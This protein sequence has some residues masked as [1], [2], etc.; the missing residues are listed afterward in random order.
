MSKLTAIIS[1]YNSGEWLDNRINN[2]MQ[3]S[4]VSDMEIVCVNANSPDPRDDDIPQRYPVTYFKLDDR[5]SVYEAWNYAIERT[6]STYIVNA[7]SDD[8]VSPECYSKLAGVLDSGYDFCYPSWFTTKVPNLKWG[9]HLPH[10]DFG[11][12][13]GNYNGDL[14][15]SGVGHFPMWRRSLHDKVGYFDGSFKALG[16]AEFWARCF[17]TAN[18]RFFWLNEMLAVYLW[19]DGLNLWSTSINSD[20]WSRYHELVGKYRLSAKV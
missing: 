15:R 11:G 3:S 18:A 5:I 6:N 13:P 12:K 16:D 2:L 7:N 9:S 20:E 19:R 8:L 1:C 4:I 14:S 10:V 17:F